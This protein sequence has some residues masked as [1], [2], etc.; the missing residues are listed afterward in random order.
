M[1]I[2]SRVLR[3]EQQRSNERTKKA[4]SARTF[5][6]AD[7]ALLVGDACLGIMR[8]PPTTASAPRLEGLLP[9]RTVRLHR[10]G[11]RLSVCLES[12]AGSARCRSQRSQRNSVPRLRLLFFVLSEQST[13]GRV[14][15]ARRRALCQVCADFTSGSCFLSWNRAPAPAPRDGWRQPPLDL[16]QSSTS[17]DLAAARSNRSQNR[18]IVYVRT[19]NE[20]CV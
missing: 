7:N 14:R 3:S 8:P 1:R 9:R 12:Q 17:I 18:P 11:Q 19:S 16:R 2:T 13:I 15:R 6:R 4:R 5:F 10:A 20:Y